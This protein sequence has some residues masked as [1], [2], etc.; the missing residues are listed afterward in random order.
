MEREFK[1]YCSIENSYMEKFIDK[2]KTNT[3]K[4]SRW[5]VT[6]KIHGCNCQ[7]T[8]DGDTVV[9]GKRNGFVE[10]GDKFYNIEKVLEPY[11]ENIKKMFEYIKQEVDIQTLTIFGELFGGHYPHPNVEPDRNASK[12]QKG[13]Y[14]HPSNRFMAFDICLDN[15]IYLCGKD[16]VNLCE[17]FNLPTVPVL[18]TNI[19]FDQALSYPNNG[20]SLVNVRYLLPKIEDNI[21]EGVVIRGWDKDYYATPL[22]R[23]ILK[24]KNDRFKEVS[25][26]PKQNKQQNIPEELQ[27]I[28]DKILCYVTPQRATNVISHFGQVKMSDMGNIIKEMYTDVIQDFEKENNDLN[29]VE[30][31]DLKIIN[32]QINNAV[33]K[34][35]KPILLQI[36]E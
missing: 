15:S 14:Y 34:T 24:N 23:A 30:K 11:K 17:Q 28:I 26:E 31:A 29:T 7:I 35:I 21:M 13:V 5:M 2:I 19:D 20:Q 12:V 9:F 3:P 25:H 32:K 36:A 6:E 22:S 10:E 4:D 18:R 33:V 27:A 1:K 8:Y 16:F